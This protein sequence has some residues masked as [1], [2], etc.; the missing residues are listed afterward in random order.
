MLRANAEQNR[1]TSCYA[2]LG[3][4]TR[5]SSRVLYYAVGLKCGCCNI[6]NWSHL[7]FAVHVSSWSQLNCQFLRS[8]LAISTYEVHSLKQRALQS[9]QCI[10]DKLKYQSTT[11]LWESIPFAVTYSLR[12]SVACGRNCRYYLFRPPG[13]AWPG[14]LYILLLSFRFFAR[15]YRWESAHR[16][17]AVTAPTVGPPAL[18]IKYPQTSDPCC[19]PFLQGATMCQILAQISTPV[20]FGPQ[21]FW[22]GAIY[23]KTKTNLSRT[24]DRP[25]IT[26][27]LG[28]V[29]PPNFQNR[30]RNW[31][32]KVKSG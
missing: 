10:H 29:G 24:D 5:P 3:Q 32:P 23:R 26:P 13:P 31:Y 17:A 9:M 16:L 4:I 2:T 27:N 11:G 8:Y 28:W 12:L 15:T 21:Y 18:L 22:T 6:Y 7:T 30:W 25:T 19:P 1:A 14:G 20:V